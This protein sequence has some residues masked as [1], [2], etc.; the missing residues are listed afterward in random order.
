[1]YGY[2]DSYLVSTGFWVIQW[3]TKVR[4][5]ALFYTVKVPF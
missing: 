2:T 4:P 5:V 3:W 1:M